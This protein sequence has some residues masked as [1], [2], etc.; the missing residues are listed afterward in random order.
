L[1]GA[2]RHDLWALGIFLLGL[3]F[4]LRS[5]YFA[6]AD[7]LG[8]GA[9][10]VA[11]L[12]GIGLDLVVASLVA[13]LGRV[14]T[15][16]VV[17]ALGALAVGDMADVGTE[18]ESYYSGLAGGTEGATLR[19]Y[20]R[21]AHPPVPVEELSVLSDSGVRRLAILTNAWELRPVIRRYR[22]IGLVSPEFELVELARAQSIVVH[23]DDTLPELYSVIRDV[24]L[25]VAG[26]PES[27]LFVGSERAPLFVF[28]R[29][30]P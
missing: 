14:A 15:V 23:V 26:S 3:P 5:I 9:I 20:S 27:T 2:A 1:G 8:V 11:I 6:G 25:F 28:G 4:L 18:F 30:A 7:L 24:A 13:R 29:I 21:Y 10:F 22:E 19:G 12:A 16:V 17:V